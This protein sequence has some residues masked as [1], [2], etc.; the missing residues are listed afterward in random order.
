MRF[1]LDTNVLSEVRRPRPD[2]RVT[3]WLGRQAPRDVAIC[4]VTVVEI[5]L[6]VLRAERRDPDSGAALRRWF[7]NQVLTGFADRILP[8][9][10]AGARATAP[11]H[12][13]DPAPERDALIA[14]VALSRDLTVV[15]RNTADFVRAGVRC[16]DPW[17]DSSMS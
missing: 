1:L 15:T 8:L 10:L 16:L 3:G 6:G 5:E 13:P 12:V 4:V 7:E 2:P 9:D 14:G 17:S 11:L